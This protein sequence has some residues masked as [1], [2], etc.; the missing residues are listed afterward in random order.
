MLTPARNDLS[1]SNGAVTRS[2][3]LWSLWKMINFSLRDFCVAVDL[4]WS[5]SGQCGAYAVKEPGGLVK[6]ELKS[7]I[8]GN[9]DYVAK[10]CV[11]LCLERA[12]S[13]IARIR[14]VL[15]RACTYSELAS[16]FAILLQAIEDDTECE[17]FFH[18]RKDK[19]L[20]AQSFS[21]DWA[22]TLSSFNST[23]QDIEEAVDCYALEH[24]TACVFH[25]MRILEHGLK[26]LA[27]GVNVIFEIQQWQNV[28][29]EIETQIEYFGNK[30]PRGAEKNKWMTFYSESARHFF[31][32]KEA[33][34]NHV[35]HNRA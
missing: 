2:G 5:H 7:I 10:Q 11:K 32:L 20:L 12:E 15:A 18:Y 33:W 24:E 13:R 9:F 6:P 17:R 27:A 25:L 35:S 3:R 19:G 8:E 21:G 16:E 26:E 29:D 1:G 31:F 4:L 34:R 30:F 23:K 14:H 22:P 28:I